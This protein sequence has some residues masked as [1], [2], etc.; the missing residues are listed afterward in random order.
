[1]EDHGERWHSMIP[2]MI[3]NTRNGVQMVDEIIRGLLSRTV[4]VVDPDRLIP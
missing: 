4:I 3:L 1:M 2:E